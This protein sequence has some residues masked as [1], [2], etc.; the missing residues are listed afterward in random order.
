MKYTPSKTYLALLLFALCLL[1]VQAQSGRRKT[2]PVSAPPVPTPTPEPTPI[3]K[4]EKDEPEL[5][6]LVGTDR[7]EAP[8]SIPLA[9]HSAAQRGCADRL[10]TRS[11]ADIDA[12]QRD[13]GRGEAIEKAKASENTYVV[14]LTLR[15][16]VMAQSY[17]DLQL[18][19]VV[20]SPMTAKVALTG[21]SYINNN[22]IGPVIAG[23]TSRLP[24]GI[25]RE[26][27]LLQAGEEAADKI[28][29]KLN[30][31]VTLPK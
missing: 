3:P 9:F 31:G 29:K 28:L 25:Y 4:K 27:W 2:K 17:D 16:D 8:A 6:F 24:A 19:F 11:A 10:R 1:T 22:R 12:P 13:M 20:F 23:R 18:D 30:L 5:L 21:R 14:L 7:N 15:L 26:Q